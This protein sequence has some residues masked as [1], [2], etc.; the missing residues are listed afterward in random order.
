MAQG[1][2]IRDMSGDHVMD[3]WDA[4]LRTTRGLIITLAR[5]AQGL[6]LDEHARPVGGHLELAAGTRVR[7]VETR[8][9]GR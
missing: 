8:Y 6:R 4:R 5:D 2:D 1:D 9:D 3:G 7:Y